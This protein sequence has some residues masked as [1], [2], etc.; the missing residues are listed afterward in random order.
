MVSRQPHVKITM[1]E[2]YLSDDVNAAL[3]HNKTPISVCQS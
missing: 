2:H 1:P 3:V